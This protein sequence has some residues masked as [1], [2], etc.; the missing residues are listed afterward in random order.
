MT[1]EGRAFDFAGATPSSGLALDSADCTTENA[2]CPGVRWD[3]Q[4]PP[5]KKPRG[6]NAGL[7]Y[8]YEM[9]CYE[10]DRSM[11]GPPDDKDTWLARA[12][13]VIDSIRTPRETAKCQTSRLARRSRSR[14]SHARRAG[15]R[16]GSRRSSS[17]D[18]GG[19]DGGG[20]GPAAGA[21]C[22]GSFERLA[23]A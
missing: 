19:S 6:A 12:Y 3:A 22:P 21:V 17:G 11:Q 2:A 1:A 14:T 15:H 5:T 23:D 4:N 10:M 13:A 7:R 18:D 16:G 8:S 9:R 20:D